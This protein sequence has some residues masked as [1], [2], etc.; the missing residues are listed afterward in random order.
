MKC[1]CGVY[2][3]IHK[4]SFVRELLP[5]FWLIFLLGTASCSIS[6]VIRTE[7]GQ[8]IGVEQMIAEVS[9]SPVVFVGER[10]DVAAHHELQLDVIKGL[11]KTGTPLVIGIEM[12]AID[13]QPVLDDW[14]ARKIPEEKFVRVYQANW[15]NLN[16]GLYQDIFLFARDHDIPMVALN[17]P[18]PIVEKVAREGF[19]ALSK[20]DL[21]A[22]PAESTVPLSEENIQFMAAH[23][24][25][26]GKNSESFRHLC[27]AQALRNRVMAK[28]I[29][30]Y[31]V[32]H[33]G[34]RMVVLTGGAHAW[35]QGGIPAEL[36]RLPYKV[37]IPPFP[38][39]IEVRAGADYLLD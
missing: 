2:L 11:H 3:K 32:N 8:R 4:L 6:H 22:I 33:P 24:P 21:R 9:N 15:H 1:A 38:S 37:I 13:N 31:L 5:A 25:G 34:A 36:G 30:R 23:H 39:A 12:F 17:V 14:I 18:Q 19:L 7:D 28:T 16:W 26:H 27:E 29:T 35:S 10:H 20:T